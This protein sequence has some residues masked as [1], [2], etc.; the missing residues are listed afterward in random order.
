MRRW[1]N[2]ADATL[3]TCGKD[4]KECEFWSSL[5]H[6]SG[7]NSDKPLLEK[8]K[9]LV[10]Q[11]ITTYGR[12]AV[13]I[14]SSKSLPVLKKLIKN[15]G[16]WG[17]ASEDIFVVLTVKDVRSFA[18]SIARKG[19]TRGMRLISMLRSFNLWH[20][21]NREFAGFLERNAFV[22]HSVCL[23][24]RLCTDTETVVN[25]LLEQVGLDPL[26][27]ADVTH[28]RSHILMGNKNFTTRNRQRV[29]YDNAWYNDDSVNLAYLL[30]RKIRNYNKHIY[31]LSQI[32]CK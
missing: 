5:L 9:A 21:Q 18:V 13:I 15:P 26:S 28:N 19:S 24:E 4:W 31:D 23:Y 29:S 27:Y 30:H 1:G 22:K 11:V 8:Y 3:C 14:D 10:G 17:I 16:D 25:R 12:D 20:F 6:L 7:L 2:Y 32:G